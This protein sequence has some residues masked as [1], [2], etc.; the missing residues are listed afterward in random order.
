MVNGRAVNNAEV[1]DG[2][3]TGSATG[4]RVQADPLNCFMNS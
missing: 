3:Q 2:M 1:G 4:I